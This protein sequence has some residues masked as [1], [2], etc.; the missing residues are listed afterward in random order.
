VGPRRRGL[1]LEAPP[2]TYDCRTDNSYFVGGVGDFSV[3]LDPESR[4]VYFYCSLYLRS[5]GQQG[6][7]VARLAWA[8]RDQPTG[9]ILSGGNWYPQVI[10][11][12]AGSGTD[13]VAGEWAWVYMMGTSQHFIRFTR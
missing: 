4:D 9:K 1:I 7:G 11:T 6:V 5:Q 13:K 10:G 8:D 12:E 2:R 3:M